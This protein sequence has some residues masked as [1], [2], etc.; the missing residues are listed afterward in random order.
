MYR[1]DPDAIVIVDVFAK[2]TGRT[3]KNV[4]E[5]RKARLGT[6]DEAR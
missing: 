1:V 4:I 6:Y 5:T 2:K 3:P